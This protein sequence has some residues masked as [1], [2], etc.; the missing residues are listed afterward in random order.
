MDLQKS[1]GAPLKAAD[2]PWPILRSKTS[3]IADLECFCSK[4][5][6]KPCTDRILKRMYLMI[7]CD[8]IAFRTDLKLILNM[9]SSIDKDSIKGETNVLTRKRIVGP[10]INHI[11]LAS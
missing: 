6:Q 3:T 11:H 7:S 8:K 4:W 9:D 10:G 1:M 5:L 2:R